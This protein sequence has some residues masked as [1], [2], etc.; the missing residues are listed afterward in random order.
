MIATQSQKIVAI[1]APA[2]IVD[3]SGFVTAALDTNGWDY[4]T[5]VVQL[6]A[7]DI[8]M[9]ALKVQTSDTDG[10]YADVTG[11]IY[12]T[13][14]NSAG[15][16]STL[17]AADSDA[18]L[19]AFHIDLRKV[20]RYLDVVATAGDGSAGTY[21]SAIAILSRGTDAPSTATGRGFA[22]ELIL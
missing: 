9:A 11:L 18:G 19:F 22:Q 1:T 7:T 5:I 4:C 6:G 17:P 13:S 3:A 15:S 2:A 20:K 12:G 8:A 16:T 21:M 10:S 14:A